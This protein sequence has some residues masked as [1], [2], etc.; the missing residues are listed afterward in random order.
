MGAGL[1]AA[2]MNPLQGEMIKAWRCYNLLSGRDENCT[3]YIN[4]STVEGERL[5]NMVVSTG[6]TT[7]ITG[8]SA[9]GNA[10]GAT[11][12]NPPVRGG[13]EQRSASEGET[14]PT[15]KPRT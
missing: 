2:I 13:S 1:S 7:A 6:S 11:G 8:S 12:G 4:W 9:G 15:L 5:T 14:S 3:D 10:G